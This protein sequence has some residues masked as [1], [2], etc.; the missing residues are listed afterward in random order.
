MSR[1]NNPDTE[2]RPLPG[3]PRKTTVRVTCR[4]TGRELRVPLVDTGL[5]KHAASLAA[6]DLAGA[7]FTALGGIE[8]R[9]A[10]TVNYMVLGG[11]DHFPAHVKAQLT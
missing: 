9:A 5:S 1:H 7:A 3:I 10:M 6:I 4:E 11:A 8:S 2:G